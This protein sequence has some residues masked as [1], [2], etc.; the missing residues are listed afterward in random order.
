MKELLGWSLDGVLDPWSYFLV[1]PART[2]L[3]LV[4][5]GFCIS[6]VYVLFYVKLGK[7]Y[8]SNLITFSALRD[9][10]GGRGCLHP[11]NFGSTPQHSL[12]FSQYLS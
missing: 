7:C 1:P 9:H 2:P 5:K 6:F 8:I 12:K 10:I 11:L 4:L 3:F